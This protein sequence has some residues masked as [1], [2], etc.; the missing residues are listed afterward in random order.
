MRRRKLKRDAKL[1][2]FWRA[3]ILDSMLYN[4]NAETSALARGFKP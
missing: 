3:G 2:A 1:E 4:K